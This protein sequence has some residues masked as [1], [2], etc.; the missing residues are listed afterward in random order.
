MTKIKKPMVSVRGNRGNYKIFV[1][2]KFGETLFSERKFKKKSDAE[3]NAKK[4][5]KAFFK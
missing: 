4:V 1:R 3:I 2:D 5:K